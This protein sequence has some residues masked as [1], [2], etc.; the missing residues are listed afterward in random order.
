MDDWVVIQP[1][2]IGEHETMEDVVGPYTI[3]AVVES[4]HSQLRADGTRGKIVA[5]ARGR[6]AN[7]HWAG[8]HEPPPGE[9]VTCPYGNDCDALCDSEGPLIRWDDQELGDESLDWFPGQAMGCI[10]PIQE[11]EA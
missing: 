9:S 6:D 11:Q 10:R 3:G 7:A 1:K 5:W 4:Q 2:P 8:M